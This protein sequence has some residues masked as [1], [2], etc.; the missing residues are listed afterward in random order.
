MFPRFLMIFAVLFMVSACS[1]DDATTMEDQAGYQQ[2]EMTGGPGGAQG[3]VYDETTSS[4]TVP[5]SAQDF[6]TN[7]GDRVLFGYDRYDL[8]PEGQQ[9]LDRQAA[10]L[11]QYPNLNITVEGHA[12]ERGTREYNLAL[13]ERRANSTKNYLV[14]R[15]VA[16]GRLNTVSYGKERPA[17]TGSNESSWAENRRTVTAVE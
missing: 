12:D 8:S 13:G 1:S 17:V 16:A 10:W 5:G 14:A 2:G 6:I 7:V 4:T 15:G 3:G 11:N 9:I